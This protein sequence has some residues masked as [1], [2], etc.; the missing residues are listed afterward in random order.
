MS[1]KQLLKSC[2]II[3]SN[4]N[5]I[6]LSLINGVFTAQNQFYKQDK[7]VRIRFEFNFLYPIEKVV[8]FSKPSVFCF[9]LNLSK[10]AENRDDALA[11]NIKDIQL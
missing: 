11:V 9:E 2:W 8:Q 1:L 10:L 7:G 6:P 4:E 5:L 3:A